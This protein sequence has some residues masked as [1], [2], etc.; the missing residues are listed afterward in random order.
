MKRCPK[1]N[2]FMSSD[3]KYWWCDYCDYEEQMK[4]TST[5]NWGD[6]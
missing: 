1:C 6:E 3:D 4:I 2:H 5:W